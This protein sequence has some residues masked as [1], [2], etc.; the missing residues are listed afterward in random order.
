MSVNILTKLAAEINK[1][2]SKSFSKLATT[3]SEA[4]RKTTEREINFRPPF[5]LDRDRIMYS[6]AFRRYTG[7]T[8]V[9]Y[10]AS[11]LDEQLT[12]RSLHTISVAQIAKTIGRFLSLNTDLIDA[13]ALGHDLGHPPFGHDGEVF[14]SEVSQQVGIGHFHH[15]I[16]S[17]RAVDV[18]AKKGTGLNLTFQTRDGIV[19]H[20]GEVNDEKLSPDRSKTEKD[21]DSY[22]NRMQSGENVD[23]APSTLEGCVVRI[24]DTIAYIGQDIEDAIRIG[25]IKREDLPE[26][27]VKVLGNS[28][29]KII[30]T[31]VNDVVLQSYEKDYVA[32]SDKI[33]EALFEL[34]KFNYAKIY[35]SPKLKVNHVKIKRGFKILFDLYIDALKKQDKTNE[36]YQHFL[37]TK[38]PVYL[39]NNPAE[40]I[41]RDFI[42]GMTDRYFVH[43][44][45]NHILPEITRFDVEN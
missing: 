42:A 23:T 44:L 32:F 11:L 28:N 21:L 12:S 9:V 38:N 39:K 37:N 36:I 31:L 2:E 6:G 7:K 45:T 30:E 26:E 3:H 43:V 40:L 8:Q 16:Q 33:A 22:I 15:N 20:N 34:K 18:I 5:A 17:L 13:I 25:L 1:A 24:T 4:R 35:K 27:P 10:F 41:V 14:L 29:G 19:S